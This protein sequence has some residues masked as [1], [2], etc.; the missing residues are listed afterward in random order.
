[1]VNAAREK[2]VVLRAFIYRV[3]LEIRSDLILIFNVLLKCALV[4]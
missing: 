3:S 2:S 4:S 1:M